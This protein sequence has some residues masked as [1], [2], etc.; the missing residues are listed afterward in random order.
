MRPVLLA[1]ALAAL[2]LAP[3]ASASAGAHPTG[4]LLVL[5]DRPAGTSARASAAAA[6]AVV[7]A[8]G[9][10]RSGHSVPQV[11]LVTVR[12]RPG[13][14]L[15]R[16]AA[17]LRADPR[18]A[19]VQPERRFTPR[20]VPD[21]PALTAA[22]T[23]PGTPPGTVVQWWAAR[24]RLPEAWDLAHGQDALVAVID[25]G[26]DATN[27]DLAG[28]I[29]GTIDLDA[30]P[31]SGP[32]TTDQNGHG[33]HVASL[34]CATAG[35]G[36]G[37]A[38]AGDGCSL[39]VVKSD[40]TDSS[41]VSAIVQATDRGADSIN[42]SFG[43][44]GRAAAPAAERRAIDYAYSR[45][46]VLVAAASDQGVEEQGDPANVLQ[47]TGTGPALG[48][49]KGLSVT[50]ADFDNRRPSFAGY[51]S[52]ISMAAYGTFRYATPRLPNSGP[53][54]I[55]AAF[56]ANPTELESELPP[57]GCR[58]TFQGDSR[59]AYLQ[60][61]SMAA[62]MVAAV[63]ALVR[64]ANPA[65]KAR[66][67]IGLLEQTASRP[68][69]TGW[70]PDLGWGILDAGAALSAALAVDRTRPVSRLRAPARVRGRRSFTL[71]W[72]GRDPSPPGVTAS[73]I[74]RYEV[75]R[76]VGGRA[77]RRIAVTTRRSLRLRGV[78]PR[79]YAF[80]TRAVD[81]AGNREARP[82]RPDARTRV[83]R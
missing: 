47:P 10:R 81:R 56:P 31:G 43:Q 69:G 8:A 76:S 82:A 16:L 68:P 65:L 2:A 63:A 74:A 14:T 52:Q 55:L 19:S 13:E 24:E 11:G 60:G 75:W 1:A 17:R 27:P 70:S 48:S 80:F 15:A 26:V 54:G 59:F 46:V 20:D 12:P 49:G 67:V 3:G 30:D 29:A 22:E 78:P 40:L 38:G 35:N 66:D 39:L 62:P 53:P 44:D 58:T 45:D 83:V 37:I 71:R 34:A 36:Y 72:T 21:D 7:D 61:T 5:L 6:S 23:T 51:G 41:I 79:T 77:P 28:R 50:A 33:T 25:Q 73:G 18:V 42:M 4:R 32:P 9:A 57:C 64:D